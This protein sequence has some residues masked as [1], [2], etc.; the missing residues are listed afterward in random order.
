MLPYL[1]CLILIQA[2]YSKSGKIYSENVSDQLSNY[3]VFNVDII[4]TGNV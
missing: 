1:S 4:V 2:A 3:S